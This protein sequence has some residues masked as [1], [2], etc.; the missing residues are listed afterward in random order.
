[1]IV[2]L[3]KTVLSLVLAVV[4]RV[5]VVV[6]IQR[7]L[8]VWVL[9]MM[10]CRRWMDKAR[11][12]FA[13]AF[14]LGNSRTFSRR[15]HLTPETS[16]TQ[17]NK[18]GP[19]G[20]RKLFLQQPSVWSRRESE[21]LETSLWAQRHPFIPFIPASKV[22]PKTAR[23]VREP[24]TLSDFFEWVWALNGLCFGVHPGKMEMEVKAGAFRGWTRH[25]KNPRASRLTDW[26]TTFRNRS[27][28][29]L[30]I[31]LDMMPAFGCFWPK[32]KQTHFFPSRSSLFG[33]FFL[34]AGWL[35]LPQ[36][37]CRRFE[38]RIFLETWQGD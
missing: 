20:K 15:E 17:L 22:A 31:S 6:R 2:I 10:I 27:P 12:H 8:E 30:Y 33:D 35:V 23:K 13:F 19:K 5:A 14:R 32:S 25:Q 26:L 37:C 16:Q 11:C 28:R 36:H 29:R 7:R 24:R 4:T 34:L 21:I 18:Q 9:M 38:A 3:T 1:M